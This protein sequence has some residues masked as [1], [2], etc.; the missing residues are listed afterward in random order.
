MAYDSISKRLKSITPAKAD[1][2]KRTE[3]TELRLTSE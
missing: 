2:R 3:N 1:D